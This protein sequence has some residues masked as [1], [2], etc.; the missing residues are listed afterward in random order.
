MKP[1]RVGSYQGLID[2]AITGQHQA[3]TDR[4]DYGS[5]AYATNPKSYSDR[6]AQERFREAQQ[7]LL[8]LAKGEQAWND[9]TARV[10]DES[11]RF[12]IDRIGEAAP[13]RKITQIEALLMAVDQWF[14]LELAAQ[15]EDFPGK[16]EAQEMAIRMAYRLF[17]DHGA[18]AR[19]MLDV[20]D[21]LDDGGTAF[22]QSIQESSSKILGI[23]Q[24]LIDNR[25]PWM[26]DF[27]A[28]G[29]MLFEPKW[30]DFQA[31]MGIDTKP[32][33]EKFFAGNLNDFYASLSERTR[34]Y[35]ET[36]HQN[37]Q[38]ASGVGAIIDHDAVK[39]ALGDRHPEAIEETL[40]Q[41]AMAN[42]PQ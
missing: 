12:G 34:E 41:K 33:W 42:R 39:K 23:G 28:G 38:I 26:N 19:L 4:L 35:F 7:E 36:I 10:V 1:E 24:L 16:S 13:D 5:L 25:E 8:R 20:K 6:S 22:I 9:F 30:P 21:C 14:R 32:L 18:L 17:E 2:W 29:K 3:V 40:W 31:F 27:M 11:R 37:T 15:R